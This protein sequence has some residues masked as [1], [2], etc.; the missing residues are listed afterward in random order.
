[1]NTGND[2]ERGNEDTT[3]QTSLKNTYSTLFDRYSGLRSG[4]GS[5][6]KQ[7]KH[8]FQACQRSGSK[9]PIGANGKPNAAAIREANALGSMER[10]QNMYDTIH[11]SANYTGSN[12]ALNPLKKEYVKQCYGINRIDYVPSVKDCDAVPARYVRVLATGIASSTN[13]MAACIQIPQLQVFDA[14]DK[15][16]ARGKRTSSHSVG[17]GGSADK[18]V[19]GD[20]RPK[21]H[22]EGEYHDNCSTPDRQFWMVDLG[23]TVRVSR[24]V[25]YPRTDC[26]TQRQIAAPVQLLDERKQ[27][28]AQQWIGQDNMPIH[29]IQNLVFTS[30]STK[31]IVPRTSM[32]PG[33]RFSL[34]SATAPD[35]FL[36]HAGF[37]IW[38]AS[39]TADALFRNDA[40]FILRPARNGN[41]GMVSFE[42]VN[43]P[44]RH[45]GF[46]C[47]LHFI[48]SSLDK[49][50]SSFAIVNALNGDP[51]MVSFRSSNFPYYYLSTR[52]EAPNEVWI[53]T[54]DTSNVWDVQ[55]ASWKLTGP[56][57]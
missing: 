9:A 36:R 30:D 18:A 8:P 31:P 27:I 17:W 24:V 20:A 23:S 13:P 35:R 41:S 39:K 25:Y 48:N 33:L 54:V 16:V 50:D 5:K 32:N 49:D 3:R 6:E 47:Y 15:E 21:T 46:R 4:E 45:A 40:T 55:R 26:C 38:S 52:R 14:Q 12:E 53:T 51:S 7:K 22:S 28:V 44:N 11:R 10:I 29:Q 37:A 1:M 34:Q 43:F 56:L 2:R 42:S 57:A 19:N